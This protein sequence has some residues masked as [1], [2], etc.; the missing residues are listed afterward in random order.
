MDNVIKSALEIAMEKVDKVG[1]ATEEERLKWKYFPQGELL[2]AKYL[3]E[4]CDM[5]AALNQYPETARKYVADGASG[6][7]LGNIGLPRNDIA[8]KTNKKAMDGLKL[9]K[10]DKARADSF[11]NQLHRL[12]DHYATQ[13]E[14]QR[15][16]AYESVKAEFESKLQQAAQQQGL[17]VP[18]KIDVE[19]HSQFQQEW[20]RAQTQLDSQYLT[21]LDE[22]KR[23]LA[24][25]S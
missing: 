4:D 6:V 9:L 21:L 14:Q 13:G 24:N 20:R 23:E 2:G 16:Q 10:K 5:A 7:M 3:K 22:Y 1:V 17:A 19:K 12:F 8:K 18:G 25:L 11:F 15:K